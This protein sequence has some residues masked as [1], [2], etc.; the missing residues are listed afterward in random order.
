[1]PTISEAVNNLEQNTILS[2]T[3]LDPDGMCTECAKSGVEADMTAERRCVRCGHDDSK[4][5]RPRTE[6]RIVFEGRPRE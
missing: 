1:M 5:Y 4:T 2:V 6:V 3:R